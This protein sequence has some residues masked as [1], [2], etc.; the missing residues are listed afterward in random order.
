MSQ[1]PQGGAPPKQQAVLA[2]WTPDSPMFVAIR[3]KQLE[4]MINVNLEPEK[5]GLTFMRLAQDLCACFMSDPKLA[6]LADSASIYRMMVMASRYQTTF[7]D[8]G[9]WPIPEGSNLRGQ[10]SEKLYTQ[11]CKE[12]TGFEIE[13]PILAYQADEPITARRDNL[14]NILDFKLSDEKFTA[15]RPFE[16]LVGMFVKASRRLP[17]GDV[18]SL[19][20]WFTKEDIE[21]YRAHSPSWDVEHGKPKGGKSPWG[22]DPKQM[23]K[24]SGRSALARQICPIMTRVP[25]MVGDPANSQIIHLQQGQDYQPANAESAAAELGAMPS[26]LAQAKNLIESQDT[27]EALRQIV[28][29]EFYK[30]L[31]AAMSELDRKEA[32]KA[33]DARKVQLGTP[34]PEAK[35]DDKPPANDTTGGADEPP[36]PYDV[37]YMML[38]ERETKASLTELW[39]QTAGK[40]H[41][42][43][44]QLDNEDRKN[45]EVEYKRMLGELKE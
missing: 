41:E 11:R 20:R 15:P 22:T 34:K 33:W 17:N 25:G 31:I 28:Q 37:C 8:G 35:A 38:A 5:T 19:I 45:I 14:G 3:S 30:E 18:E 9:I 10:V 12:N 6:V 7:G 1:A 4:D 36:G 16:T 40:F 44:L 39:E 2:K 42:T 26:P 29:S 21:N 43:S 24:R 27:H 32:R 13:E 23:A